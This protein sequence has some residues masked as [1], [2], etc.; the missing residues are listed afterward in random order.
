[1]LSSGDLKGGLGVEEE[2]KV[3]FSSRCEARSRNMSRDRVNWQQARGKNISD[4]ICH[5]IVAA[6]RFCCAILK[7]VE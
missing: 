1:M 4:G 5:G 3:R 6:N 7:H 2:T